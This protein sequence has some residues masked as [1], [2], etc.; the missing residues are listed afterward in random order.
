MNFPE[1]KTCFWFS[2]QGEWDPEDGEYDEEDDLDGISI[3]TDY[4]GKPLI[5]L[6][7][8]ERTTMHMT[9]VQLGELINALGQCYE[10]WPES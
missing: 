7:A 8:I 3:S 9:K 1:G 5:E 2:S 10:E 6:S 4:D